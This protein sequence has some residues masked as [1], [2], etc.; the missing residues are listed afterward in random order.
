MDPKDDDITGQTPFSLEDVESRLSVLT[1]RFVKPARWEVDG[2]PLL[3]VAVKVVMGMILR[4]E[5][6][7]PQPLLRGNRQSKQRFPLERV[8]ANQR[9]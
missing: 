3:V 6:L 1:A 7:R 8:S 4:L 2:H 5:Q 9:S